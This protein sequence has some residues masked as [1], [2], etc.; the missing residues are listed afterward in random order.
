MA[1]DCLNNGRDLHVEPLSR[2]REAL[3]A[4]ID[5]GLLMFPARRLPAHGLGAWDIV[6]QRGLEGLVAKDER[7]TYR[8]GTTRSWLLGFRH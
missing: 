5:G 6:K 8:G 4:A 1:F 7:S 3:E 2:R